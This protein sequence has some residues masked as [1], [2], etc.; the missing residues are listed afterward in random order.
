MSNGTRSPVAT[1]QERPPSTDG[2]GPQ[3]ARFILIG[4]LNML[5]DVGV[6]TLEVAVTRIHTGAGLVALNSVSFSIATLNSYFFNH[7]WTF[8]A[9]RYDARTFTRFLL[10][11][12]GG[13]FVN[14]GTIYVAAGLLAHWSLVGPLLRTDA[15]KLFAVAASTIW[16]FAWYRYWVFRSPAAPDTETVSETSRRRSPAR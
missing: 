10:V 16:N 3:F 4:L 13:F 11:S 9:G 15:A 12:I 2:A 1:P 5:V 14:D 6:L 7:R 8:R